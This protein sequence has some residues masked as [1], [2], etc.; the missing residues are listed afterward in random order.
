MANKPSG[1]PVGRPVGRPS[2]FTQEMADKICE[3]IAMGKALRWL[4]RQDG[5]P[6]ERTVNQWLEKNEQFAQQYARARVMQQ[7][8]FVD[9][10]V[11]IADDQSIPPDRARVMIDTRKWVAGKM[12]PKKYSD[13]IQTEI[14]GPGGA[15]VKIETNVLD[16]SGLDVEELE[17]LEKALTATIK[18]E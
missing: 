6:A 3:E 14:S 17:A 5:W 16:V 12:A 10:M 4:C 7:D 9:E 8:G 1:R 2:T 11:M 18:R 13:K 15:P